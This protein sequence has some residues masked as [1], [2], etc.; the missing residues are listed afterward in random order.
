MKLF[1]GWC[2]LITLLVQTVLAQPVLAQ[3]ALAQSSDNLASDKSAFGKKSSIR[4]VANEW[5]PYTSSHIDKGGLVIELVT[6]AMAEEGIQVSF[7]ILPWAR[8]MASVEST[9]A[10][11]IAA[12]DSAERRE[13]FNYSESF[14]VNRMVFV[15]R[16]N[17]EDI[18]W[19]TLEDLEPYT[20]VLMRGAV[21][22][23]QFDQATTLKKNYVTE[24]ETALTMVARGRVDMTV[25][26]QGMVEY[27]IKTKPEQFAGKLSFVAKELSNSP[28]HLIVSKQHPKGAE[29]LQ[30]FNRG[31]TKIKAN[32]R[33]Q[34]LLE[35]YGSAS[36]IN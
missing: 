26:D 23:E 3:S 10:D 15:K 32:G 27:L 11:V 28:L 13:K 18:R 20:F 5:P 29:I 19:Q 8:A 35:K 4:I 30:R 16:L 24:E 25:R 6:A 7:S 33:Y 17:E 36:D 14:L 31:I 9:N 22:E 34:Q 21:N 1:N 12:W 2:L